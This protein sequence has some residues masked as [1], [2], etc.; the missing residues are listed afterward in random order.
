M[1]AEKRAAKEAM[2]KN[3]I[4]NSKRITSE[5]LQVEATPQTNGASSLLKAEPKEPGICFVFLN[6]YIFLPLFIPCA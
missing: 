3:A 4:E 2:E 5:S 1:E 6:S